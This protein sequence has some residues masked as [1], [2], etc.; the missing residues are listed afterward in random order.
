[1]KTHQQKELLNAVRGYLE[2]KL[3]GT[4]HPVLSDDPYYD[5]ELGLFVTLQIDGM[6]RG[7]IG[8]IQGF[9]PLRSSLF[10]MAEAAAFQDHRFMPLTESELD[11][12]EIE[13]SILTELTEVHDY[14]DIIIGTDGILLKHGMRQAVFLPQVAP[15]QG[16]DLET[17]LRHLSRKAGLPP[18]AFKDPETSFEVFQ[19]DVFSESEL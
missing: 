5:K 12:I 10:E 7:C 1:M 2:H 14:Q 17:T 6:L 11:R 3:R 18:N 4:E 8:Y 19:A 13:I 15:E 16:W 9:K